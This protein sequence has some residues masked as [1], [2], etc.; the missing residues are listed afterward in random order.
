MQ[1]SYILSLSNQTRSLRGKGQTI[2]FYRGGGGGYHFWDLQANF[3]R[4]MCFKQFF[5]LHFVMKTIFLWSFFK[6]NYRLFYRS[7]LNKALP[8]HAY[9]WKVLSEWNKLTLNKLYILVI[10]TSLFYSRTL[11]FNTPTLSPLPIQVVNVISIF[12]NDQ[13]VYL[14]SK[15]CMPTANWPLQ[16]LSY[17]YL[18]IVFTAGQYS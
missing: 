6:K 7:Y 1:T 9:T 18:V 5:S 14:Q 12:G 17:F 13:I 15:G 8:V 3:L 2:I 16:S 10:M 4:V 11:L